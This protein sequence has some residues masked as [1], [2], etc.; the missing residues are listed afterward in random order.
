MQYNVSEDAISEANGI[1]NA[2]LY[3]GKS[4]SIPEADK[5]L[6]YGRIAAGVL[7]GAAVVNMTLGGGKKEE[8]PAKTGTAAAKKLPLEW[9]DKVRGA[10]ARCAHD[11]SSTAQDAGLCFCCVRCRPA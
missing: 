9:E 2:R 5:G 1:K 10:R 4:I 7:A 11:A 6:P 3:S 8:A